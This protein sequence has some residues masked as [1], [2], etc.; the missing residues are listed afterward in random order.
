MKW[1]C[2]LVSKIPKLVCCYD[3]NFKLMVIKHVQ[4]TN[5]FPQHGNSVTEWNV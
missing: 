1:K 3:D 4:E 2:T 5:I